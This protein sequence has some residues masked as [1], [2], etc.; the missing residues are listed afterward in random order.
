MTSPSAVLVR[1]LVDPA[2]REEL[3][4]DLEEL[5]PRR[6][7]WRTWL[8]ATSVCVRQS[9]FRPRSPVRAAV[10]AL[11][12]AWAALAPGPG[13]GPHTVTAVD[14]G[15]SF[16]LTFQGPRVIAATLDGALLPP[17]RLVQTPDR[18]VIRGGDANGARDLNIRLRPDGRIYWRPRAPDPALQP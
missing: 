14:P 3:L 4:G 8:D 6:A 2:R 7:A 17:E 10:A 1:W 11:L 15:G 18:L 12:L 16:S 5:A 9:R 13:A